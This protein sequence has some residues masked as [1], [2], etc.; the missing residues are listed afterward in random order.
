MTLLAGCL[1]ALIAVLFPFARR[2][3]RHRRHTRAVVSREAFPALTGA[4]S[5]R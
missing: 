3:L 4:V 1:I 2:R 5:R